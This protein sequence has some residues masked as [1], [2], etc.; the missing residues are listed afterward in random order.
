MT[1]EELRQRAVKWLTNR[2][3]CSVVLSEMTSAAW[4]IP[5]AIGWKVATSFLVECKVS[6]S[7]FRANRNKAH[8]RSRSGVG[9]HRYFL[10]PPNLVR[11][12]DLAEVGS[13]GVEPSDYGLLWA[14]DDYIHVVKEATYRSEIDPQSE[15][16]M[17][18]S[19]LRR[20]RTR[21][22]LTIVPHEVESE[23]SDFGVAGAATSEQAPRPDGRIISEQRSGD[24][25]L[26]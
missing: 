21:E 12:E 6:R 8:V 17:L 1:H 10:T 18:V 15:T 4:E 7:D 26:I 19:A 13:E 22:F 2:K 9:R 11:V 3:R 25:G 14:A 16:A 20:V 5:D 23:Q 24:G